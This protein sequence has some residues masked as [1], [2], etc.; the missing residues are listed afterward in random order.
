MLAGIL[1]PHESIKTFLFIAALLPTFLFAQEDT[2]STLIIKDKTKYSEEFLSKLKSFT[3]SY[4]YQLLDSLLIVGQLD[5]AYFPTVLPL[6]KPRK[7][8][9]RSKDTRYDL[10]LSRINYTTVYYRLTIY[11][12][13][14]LSSNQKGHADIG[15][16][17]FLG[18]ETDEDEK[19]GISYGSTA[20]SNQTT[21]CIL[22]IRIG[23]NEMQKLCAKVTRQCKDKT[24]DIQLDDCPTLYQ[25]K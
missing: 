14:K 15:T 12:A 7:L 21:D 13:G 24:K 8:S 5:T 11:K 18:F 25:N 22:S 9:G 16:G 6:K 3:Y 2:V 19:T 10:T 17:F 4:N 20:Y 1:N 23:K